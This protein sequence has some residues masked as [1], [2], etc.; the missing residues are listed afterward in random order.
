M[1]VDEF[2][3]AA[4]RGE[5]APLYYFYGD[6]PYLLERA[7]KR[8]QALVVAPD[9]R[10]FNLDIF[11]G[12]ECKGEEIAA[13]AQT[14]PM[15]AE[16][17]LVLVKRAGELSAA[18]LEILTPCVADPS[19]GTC[20]V[21]AGEK[22]DQ[23]KKF[24][25]EMKKRGELVECKRPYENQLG[26]FIREEA[27]ALGKRIE[28]AAAEML[29]YLAGNNLSELAAQI[30]KVVTFVGTRDAVTV[31]DVREVVSDTKVESVF[32]LANA[33]GERD[34]AKSLRSLSTILRDGEAPLMLLAMIARHF[35]QLWRVRELAVRRMP[36]PDIAKATG[37]NPYFLK[38]VMEQ[39]RNFT[40]AELA[41]VF[42]ALY[43]SDVALKGGG[44][45]PTLTMER[46]VMEICG[47]RV[48]L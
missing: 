3:K 20:L 25:Q 37:I 28:A 23:R 31:G 18:A 26:N 6:E 43:A 15:F 34:L 42:E 19:P 46:L 12:N 40:V 33:L 24:F 29:V 22:I 21:F 48:R 9:F 8:L 47:V 27:R 44:R 7:V 39:A 2:D 38:G 11:Y 4:A 30:E 45:K 35:R 14:L 16:R 5:I 10:D 36:P 32:D 1:K 17:R 41:A 13:A